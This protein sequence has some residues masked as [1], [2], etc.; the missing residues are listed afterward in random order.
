M[1][2]HTA[3]SSSALPSLGDS[4]L[5]HN[6]RAD[7]LNGKGIEL[8]K[9]K[10]DNDGEDLI[11]FPASPTS[12]VD[13]ESNDV[14]AELQDMDDNLNEASLDATTSYKSVDDTTRDKS[15]R[16]RRK[17][18]ANNNQLQVRRK[19]VWERAALRKKAANDTTFTGFESIYTPGILELE[20]LRGR[21]IAK[22]S[23]LG[24]LPDAFVEVFFNGMLVGKSQ[25]VRTEKN[26]TWKFK[27]VMETS[28]DFAFED[29]LLTIVIY[30]ADG[31]DGED[32]RKDY[33]DDES[34]VTA[35]QERKEKKAA[36]ERGGSIGAALFSALAASVGL[37]HGERSKARKVLGRCIIEGD[38]LKIVA[39]LKE[40]N[41]T[42]WLTAFDDSGNA[43][44]D[45]EVLGHFIPPL[46]EH[47]PNRPN[48]PSGDIRNA[49]RSLGADVDE[50]ATA[51][52]KAST[53][54][55]DDDDEEDEDEDTEDTIRI[56]ILAAKNL[57]K[58]NM[59]GQSNS[60][61][62]LFYNEKEVGRTVVVSN[63]SYPRWDNQEFQ[64]YVPA[65][66]G[67]TNE[68][69]SDGVLRIDVFDKSLLGADTFLGTTAVGG[70]ELKSLLG[71]VTKK[72]KRGVVD[73]DSVATVST[74][75]GSEVTVER[76]YSQWVNLGKS[77]SLSVKENKFVKGAMQI[78]GAYISGK[79]TPGEG[80]L[81]DAA[82]HHRVTLNIVSA[83]ELSQS[84]NAMTNLSKKSMFG[85]SKKE[86]K[87]ENET[88]SSM[89]VVRWNG[90][91]V[92]RT[93]V[94]TS[95]TKPQYNSCILLRVPPV[96]TIRQCELEIAVHGEPPL[97]GGLG[98]FLGQANIKGEELVHALSGAC[99]EGVPK[100]FSFLLQKSEHFPV[101]DQS[102]VGGYI[103]LRGFV[104]MEQEHVNHLSRRG[105]LTDSVQ[106]SA[107]QLASLDG[108]VDISQLKNVYHLELRILECT[109]LK[110]AD[111]FGTANAFVTTIWN[112]REKGS[113]PICPNQ[114]N[115]QWENEIFYLP[116]PA[117][118]L[119]LDCSLLV[120]VQNKSR[121]GTISFLGEANISGITLE[122][123]VMN[124]G[125]PVW[126][127][128]RPNRYFDD[129]QNALVQGA[130]RISCRMFGD[131]GELINYTPA[132]DGYQPN[133]FTL[134][135]RDLT[136]M[137]SRI[138]VPKMT[139]VTSRCQP[140]LQFIWNGSEVMCSSPLSMAY[141][142]L[143][144]HAKYVWLN[145]E[146]TFIIPHDKPLNKCELQVW[147]WDKGIKTESDEDTFC[148]VRIFTGVELH[149]LI[150][151]SGDPTSF[152]RKLRL[153]KESRTPIVYDKPVSFALQKTWSLPE[154]SQLYAKGLITLVAMFVPE[155]QAPIM[156][157]ENIESDEEEQ[158]EDGDD[159]SADQ[160]NS[161]SEFGKLLGNNGEAPTTSREVALRSDVSRQD[162]LQSEQGEC[163][164]L[165]EEEQKEI[166]MQELDEYW[167]NQKERHQI[168]IP[169]GAQCHFTKHYDENLGKFY[170]YDHVSGLTTWD[171][172]LGDI[173]LY[174]SDDQIDKIRQLHERRHALTTGVEADMKD[175][176][177]LVLQKMKREKEREVQ[178]YRARMKAEKER[179]NKNLWQRVLMDASLSHGHLTLA[180]QK[181]GYID[182]VV[183]DFPVNFG[184]SL[185]SLRLIGIGLTHLPDDFGSRF[186]RLEILSLSNNELV[187]LPDS[188]V[189][190]TSLREVNLLKNKLER[191]PE[192]IGLMCS[193]Q[194]LE[195]A[196]NSIKAL[197]ITF[198]ALNLMER[199]DVEC[200]KLAVLP[201]NLD[202]LTSCTTII[203]NYNELLRLPRC[204]G[205]MP[206]LTSLSATNNKISYIP[207]EI[208]NCRSLK[209]L[210]LS[211]NKIST[212]P[213]KLGTL[214]KLKELTLDYNNLYKFPMSFYQLTRLKTFRIEGNENLS[215]PPPEVIGQGAQA[216]VLYFKK[217]Y[218]EDIS[219]RQRVIISSVQ[220]VLA[221]AQE[222]KITDP[223][224]F[225][226][227]TR[228]E[229]SED[230]WYAIQLSYFWAEL[231][232]EMKRIWRDEGLKNMRNPNWINSFPFTER[233]VLWAFSNFSDA[234]GV[235]L[236]RQ[237]ARFR[238]CACV[239][240]AGR[241]RPCVPPAVGFMCYRVAT[242]LKM[243]FI[244][245]GQRK[246]RLWVAYKKAG[247]EESVKTAEAEALKYLTSTVGKL[248]LETE[249]YRR[250]ES[251]LNAMGGEAQQQWRAKALEM[252]KSA[253]VA[254]YDRKIAHVEMVRAT[255]SSAIQE[256]L[257]N[258][259]E[260]FKKAK[261]GY[262][263]TTLEAQMQDLKKQLAT[264]DE[265]VHLQL[266]NTEC[267]RKC[268]DVVN[269]LYDADS[270][271][272]SD[273]DASLPDSEDESELA[274]LRRERY[275]RRHEEEIEKEKL[276][277][278]KVPLS[279]MP[280][281]PV[282][283]TLKKVK[284]KLLP[285]VSAILP[286]N[287]AREKKRA[288]LYKT[289][290]KTVSHVIDVVDIRV[291]KF[292]MKIG[293]NFDE[294]QKEAR[295]ELYRQY[296]E[297]N[298]N[299]ARERAKHEFEV[300]DQVRQSMGG[301]GVE[302]IFKAWKRW[303]L[304][305][306]QRLRRDA[307]AEFRVSTKVFRAAM[308]SVDIAQAQVDM[309]KRR[310]DVYSEKPFWVNV[311]T[312]EI[313]TDK[314]GL[315][316]FLP[317]SF[318]MPPP[319][320]PLPPGV[321]EDTSSDESE[322]AFRKVKAQSK[323]TAP[324]EKNK[325]T[326]GEAA[327]KQKKK[328]KRRKSQAS[329][330]SEGADATNREDG[331][332]SS[333]LSSDSSSGD[334]S[335]RSSESDA[336][337]DE[338]NEN[339]AATFRDDISALSETS[340]VQLSNAIAKLPEIARRKSEAAVELQAAQ[341]FTRVKE[342]DSIG[343]RDAA[344][345]NQFQQ[346]ATKSAKSGKSVQSALSS[347]MSLTSFNYG[348]DSLRNFKSSRK[349]QVGLFEEPQ[350]QEPPP[351]DLDLR[352]KA[353]REYLQSLQ[354]TEHEQKRDMFEVDPT[355]FNDVVAFS[356][357]KAEDEVNKADRIIR[358][359]RSGLS[360]ARHETYLHQANRPQKSMEE[361]KEIR[362]QQAVEVEKYVKPD[363]ETLIDLAG[364]DARMTNLPGAQGVHLR[365]VLAHRVMHVEK[366]IHERAVK[367][368]LAEPKPWSYIGHYIAP[369]WRENAHNTDDEDSEDDE[370]KEDK[371]R[372]KEL[373]KQ[374]RR[375]IAK[376]LLAE[377]EQEEAQSISSLPTVDSKIPIE[378]RMGK[379]RNKQVKE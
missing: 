213:D 82:L 30:D 72:N 102:L 39:A 233:E 219:W 224:Q 20:I 361:I 208:T 180:W 346:D 23:I 122:S 27:A 212:I 157:L 222:R 57:S 328:S 118:I 68:D 80:P 332:A 374:E 178:Q 158:A 164:V 378:E 280:L 6:F 21:N 230:G 341:A 226:P 147:M 297:S 311:V 172:P 238:R 302:K 67:C 83:K 342:I 253:I 145:E 303:A 184:Y 154:Q 189:Q 207:E 60:Y 260:E 134:S 215:D 320:K 3:S 216:I 188:F 284:E 150:C 291:R 336:E 301:V 363:L 228:V 162:G 86:G 321:S 197:P 262:M 236:R 182:P 370:E 263:K 295:H 268:K 371:R 355:N 368:K 251:V 186:M 54:K 120:K 309:W 245:A 203:C 267:E 235:M 2:R 15:S 340:S 322:H 143:D 153:A 18:A 190:M 168:F 87:H 75:N 130:I 298:V 160:D 229:D 166:I 314:P 282:D 177:Q 338:D 129:K 117:S 28:Q 270:T 329:G 128:L 38:S 93:G 101:E 50:E 10:N 176:R 366:K 367:K 305:K 318:K 179:E 331:D 193:L 242:L 136:C 300:I 248:W 181:L 315:E 375:E 89:C 31:G 161:E 192:R 113:T 288:A 356:K 135:L 217:R 1:K 220:A 265:N 11:K 66:S 349:T 115:P 264:M 144:Y 304:N 287:R 95:T 316:H 148:G 293:G 98:V 131:D 319:P 78:T 234:Y 377:R 223:S 299:Q 109:E 196:N 46:V 90:T 170:Y 73:E 244:M 365:T 250:A 37:A 127:D 100:L 225:E 187:Y 126:Y 84:S 64:I 273:S 76:G 123:L 92:G 119:F 317:P 13:D 14:N 261:E 354:G 8:A 140:Y 369:I 289:L 210:R 362:R 325:P 49:V 151:K 194:R 292:Y 313:T 353:A 169:D 211:L 43:K 125:E 266:L 141:L 9:E 201:E 359:K 106:L 42:M 112:G 275:V 278:R 133:R 25:I 171:K 246:E 29:C 99:D 345:R 343:S 47:A 206:S 62:V 307:R 285:L 379:P 55:D 185:I 358:K 352:V 258:V 58:V 344:I 81:S 286:H 376:K 323:K 195:V 199:M 240:Q 239:D 22:S 65:G 209:I 279:E 259:K 348:P 324:G 149:F 111:K 175:V 17:N 237:K 252:R 104:E 290:K 155:V 36:K 152:E 91:E 221:Q 45:V 53:A 310:T 167:Q 333:D 110:Q 44:G 4:P 294:I 372:R 24:Y 296:L 257:D 205:L 364:G 326:K 241:R 32:W 103:E 41:S 202:N 274:V 306:S 79:L 227:D 350:P 254:H 335:S 124:N 40:T 243:H 173:P 26:P 107:S 255:K 105:A 139:L 96:W 312:K 52:S 19:S 5:I 108:S 327:S 218:E 7:S 35:K 71:L 63:S 34:D 281:P 269:Q 163:V 191:L 137:P 283:Y 308:E 232:P 198:G 174:L 204:I 347:E 159:F 276:S 59:V 69:G 351:S 256:E 138:G 330:T 247:I 74:G 94:V 61:A 146:Y 183:Y 373:R 337:S 132:K 334:A 272:S 77:A 114:L 85:N 277:R 214:H 339:D 97:T 271:D 48:E 156:E 12:Q 200:N 51:E 360:M 249:A 357:K 121:L 70:N 116:I 56:Q 16:V 142:D 33:A 165:T 231:V 88:C